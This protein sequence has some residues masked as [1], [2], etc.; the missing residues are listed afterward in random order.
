MRKIKV[1]SVLVFLVALSLNAQLNDYKYMVIPKKFKEFKKENQYQTS[2]LLKYLFVEASY[3]AIYDDD[4]VLP[5]DLKQNACLALKADLENRS[6]L[7]T[8]KVKIIVKDCNGQVVFTSIEG[9]SKQ[10]DYK[11]AYSDAI[12]KAFVSFQSLNYVY[13]EKE[14]EKSIVV[15]FKNDVKSLDEEVNKKSSPKKTTDVAIKEVVSEENKSFKSLEP[16][17]SK[18]QSDTEVNEIL[19]NKLEVL[20]AQAT[21]NGFQLVDNTPKIRYKLIKTSVKNVFLATTYGDKNGVVLNKNGKWFFEYNEEGEQILKE[22]NI[23]F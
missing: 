11:M 7:F 3:N 4:D 14:P 15:S 17:T 9:R 1:L 21:E 16:A 12:R 22:L 2:T 10:K 6:S 8:T 20:Y 23:K 5:N 18:Y 13:K 19:E